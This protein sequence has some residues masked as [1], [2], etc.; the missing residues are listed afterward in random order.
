[1][2]NYKRVE[3]LMDQY[4]GYANQEIVCLEELR[5]L[6]NTLV[7][8]IFYEVTGFQ[9]NEVAPGNMGRRVMQIPLDE[10]VMDV[11]RM[12]GGHC[13]DLR[14]SEFEL[15]DPRKHPLFGEPSLLRCVQPTFIWGLRIG[16]LPT[17]LDVAVGVRR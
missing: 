17:G 14:M 6:G 9:V 3:A 2:H 15:D 8:E 7:G 16:H 13:V 10:R 12:K 11:V 4:I 5:H 1:M